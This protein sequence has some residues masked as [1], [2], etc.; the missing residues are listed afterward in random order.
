MLLTLPTGGGQTVL[1]KDEEEILKK[2]PATTYGSRSRASEP[3]REFLRECL[4]G[5]IKSGPEGRPFDADDFCDGFIGETFLAQLADLLSFR[6]QLL[7][8][9]EQLIQLR[10]L[11]KHLFNERSV[12]RN[13]V[14]ERS[15]AVRQRIVK[16][17]GRV[18]VELAVEAVA[19]AQPPFAARAE[20]F[21]AILHTLPK[22]SAVPVIFAI[23]VLGDLVP[24]AGELVVDAFTLVDIVFHVRYLRSL[25]PNRRPHKK[26]GVTGQTERE[27]NSFRSASHARRLVSLFSCD[28]HIRSSHLCAPGERL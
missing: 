7:Q 24:G 25:L 21:A 27:F 3:V 4:L 18:V 19:V 5:L 9:G 14:G 15:L 8:A 28:L 23:L 10:L 17:D 20:A 6:H 13:V 11:G 22:R 1:T 16:R 26:E 2:T 12:V